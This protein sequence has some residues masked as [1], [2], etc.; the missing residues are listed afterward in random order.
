MPKTG[1]KT[2]TLV[3]LLTEIALC[4]PAMH[5]TALMPWVVGAGRALIGVAVLAGRRILLGV[6]GGIAAYKCAELVRRLVESGAEV[7]VVMTAAAQQFITPL[8]LQ[9]V[10]GRPVR[11]ALLDPRAEAGMGH[12][13]LARW[14][15]LILVA[16]ASAD[17]LARL[18]HGLADDLL[19]TVC[20]ASDRPLMVAP[21]M[22]TLMWRHPA[23]VDNIALLVRRGA[24][25]LGPDDGDQACGET[26]PG[27]MMEPAGLLAALQQFLQHGALA[28]LAGKTVLISAGPTREALDP[29]RFLSNRS[30]G[31]MGYAVA[32]ATVRAGARVQLVSGPVSLATPPAVER[33]DVETGVQMYDAVMARAAAADLFIAVAAVSDYRPRQ[34]A[35]QKIK[36]Q[37]D[38]LSLE[39]VRNPDI[40]AEVAAMRPG[41]FTVGF[42]A[43]TESLRAHAEGKRLAKG[44]DMIVGNCVGPGLGFDTAD[45]ELLVLWEG[46]ELTLPRAAKRDLAGGL[47]KLVAERYLADH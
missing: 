35:P 37:R 22:N 16:P 42:A 5:Y 1:E 28:V 26:G 10:S 45:N 18:A 31:A 4:L 38:R 30:S 27:R 33:I 13:E 40:V 6:T 29:V 17:M 3:T 7:Q 14:A 21:A 32:A 23:T 47:I 12:I 34:A 9:A 44:L 19:T 46:G 2:S 20:L 24:Q 39:L 43:E 8:T 11:S 41:P 15:E 25:V 36:K